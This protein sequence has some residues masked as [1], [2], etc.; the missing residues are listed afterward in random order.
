[1][2][3]SAIRGGP[4]R[5]LRREL[6]VFFQIVQPIFLF[7]FLVEKAP[8]KTLTI[9]RSFI[10]TRLQRSLFRWRFYPRLSLDLDFFAQGLTVKSRCTKRSG[11][12]L[13]CGGVGITSFLWPLTLHWRPE[14]RPTEGV[15]RFR[16]LCF[17]AHLVYPSV[18][19]VALLGGLELRLNLTVLGIGVDRVEI[20]Y[21]VER[22]G[23]SSE[24]SS[25]Y[26]L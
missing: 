25:L 9:W 3:C 18:G 16:A 15:L 5:D 13:Y 12:A 24:N 4:R 8:P 17:L 10:F 6:G 1:M 22:G 2:L 14:D 19:W 7:Y 23:G 11:Y 26:R 21:P 20:L